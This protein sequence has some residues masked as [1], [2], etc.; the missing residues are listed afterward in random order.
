MEMKV[1][2]ILI[3]TFALFGA[4]QALPGFD[5]KEVMRLVATV[6]PKTCGCIAPQACNIR[7]PYSSFI[8]INCQAGTNVS[9][10]F[11]NGT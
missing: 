4:V 10:I 7:I 8:G 1:T 2:T 3:A 5:V 11:V 6:E 9:M